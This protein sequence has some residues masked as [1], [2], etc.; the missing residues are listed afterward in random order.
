VEDLEGAEFERRDKYWEQLEKVRS[1]QGKEEKAAEKAAARAEK[2]KKDDDEEAG[3]SAAPYKPAA[4]IKIDG[5]EFSSDE[6]MPDPDFSY[7]SMQDRRGEESLNEIIRNLR[8]DKNDLLVRALRRGLGM[9]H[10]G[11]PTKYRQA[12]EILFR[13]VLQMSLQ[14]SQGCLFC[15]WRFS[16]LF[17][18]KLQPTGKWHKGTVSV[19]NFLMKQHLCPTTLV[20]SNT[21]PL[22]PAPGSDPTRCLHQ[23]CCCKAQAE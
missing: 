9:H 10:S 16:I 11:L 1:R 13:Y 5:F 20:P 21:Q 8:L 12:V 15:I 4:M 18:L 6:S 19:S 22:P 7:C 14:M 17:V 2:Q 23:C 3:G